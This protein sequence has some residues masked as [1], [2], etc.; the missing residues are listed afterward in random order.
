MLEDWQLFLL[1][2]ELIISNK[3]LIVLIP[4]MLSNNSVVHINSVI[5]I[6]NNK[7]V[8]ME[9]FFVSNVF[10]KPVHSKVVVVTEIFVSFCYFLLARCKMNVCE[11]EWCIAEIEVDWDGSFVTYM[12]VKPC[13][14]VWSL[15]ICDFS[16][17]RLFGIHKYTRSNHY[18]LRNLNIRIIFRCLCIQRFSKQLIPKLQSLVVF[19]LNGIFCVEFNELLQPD[20]KEVIIDG[21]SFIFSFQNLKNILLW[22]NMPWDMFISLW[23]IYHF[24]LRI[25]RRVFWCTVPGDYFESYVSFGLIRFLVFIKFGFNQIL[26]TIWSLTPSMF[27]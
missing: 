16:H 9:W 11:A 5:G 10:A 17:N 7:L 21:V 22:I 18:L 12:A 25:C 19:E 2:Q 6:A 1:V 24:N 3:R 14:V 26:Y 27:A 20:D 23:V 4:N 8:V 15:N 13:F